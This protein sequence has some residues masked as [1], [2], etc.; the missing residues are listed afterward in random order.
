LLAGGGGGHEDRDL[1]L[2]GQANQDV[3]LRGDQVLAGLI[4]LG[5]EDLA[6]TVLVEGLR[7]AVGGTRLADDDG[8]RGAE[9]TGGG[10]QLGGCVLP[11]AIGVVDEYEDISHG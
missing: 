8:G 11:L 6:R 7:E 3:D 9:G 10:Q 5:G 4:G 2:G 1:A